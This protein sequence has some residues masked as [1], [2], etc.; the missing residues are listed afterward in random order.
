MNIGGHAFADLGVQGATFTRLASGEDTLAIEL[1][2]PIDA[3]DIFAPY[4]PYEFGDED[5]GYNQTLWLDLRHLA[6]QPAESRQLQFTS[7][8][9]FLDLAN[10]KQL[11]PVLKA[12][13]TIELVEMTAITLGQL[14][15]LNTAHDQTSIEK[16]SAAAQIAALVAQFSEQFPDIP[17]TGGAGA[18]DLPWSLQTNATIGTCLLAILRWF[19]T[20]LVRSTS[21]GLEI[22]DGS[23]QPARE[24]TTAG[25]ESVSIRP[26][27]DLLASETKITYTKP[28]PQ[29]VTL[30]SATRG[31]ALQASRTDTATTAN[32]SPRKIHLTIEL[33]QGEEYPDSGLAAIYQA[34]IG[35]L[36]LDTELQ[37]TGDLR[38]EIR[39]GDRLALGGI[40]AQP[41][42]DN[43]I[44][45]T[46]S[47]DLFARTVKVQAGPRKHLG[48]DQ[49]VELVRKRTK[50]GG[51]DN[52]N[53]DP[54]NSTGSITVNVSVVC[55]ESSDEADALAQTMI[56]VGD[57]TKRPEGG[58]AVFSNLPL[59]SYAIGVACSGGWRLDPDLSTSE[60]SG[61]EIE[62]PGD[63][64]TANITVTPSSRLILYKDS[65]GVRR[66]IVLD[67]DDLPADSEVS[68]MRKAK[69]NAQERCD[70]K[71][72]AFLGT[73]WYD[74]T[75]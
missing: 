35:R 27:H 72:A 53:S 41:G 38:W 44:V 31:M 30:S 13:G 36:M 55:E 68:G 59:G 60:L 39:P 54:Y 3:A 52:S 22:V 6:A 11:R 5:A 61:I 63:D 70:Q 23:G 26:R 10:A 75:E 16:I 48:L 69:F 34:Y 32:G 29:R 14:V 67:V 2:K 25:L 42:T 46:V 64:K 4:A 57:Q 73:D 17:F 43:P 19:P 71:Q 37:I 65:G 8:F 20:Y 47:R 45:Q 56:T 24:V 51:T 28:V 66:Y 58:A 62:F 21:G 15:T 18:I 74:P 50:G 40:L 49:L 7:A 12:D 33:E 1:Q 9:R